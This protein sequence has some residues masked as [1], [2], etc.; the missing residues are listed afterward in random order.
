LLPALQR[1]PHVKL[2]PNA[3]G[4]IDEFLAGWSTPKASLEDTGKP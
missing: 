2:F 4:N 1:D 3:S